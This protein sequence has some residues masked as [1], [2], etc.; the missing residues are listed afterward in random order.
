MSET[1]AVQ[2]TAVAT[3]ALAALALATAIL[4]LLAWRKQS[5]E[6]RDQ[7]EML[8]LQAEE[9]SQV[10]ADRE[11]E[12]LER[13]RA[14]AVQ[15]YVW[16][17]L[18]DDG[19]GLVA[20]VRN[21]SEQPVYDVTL[22]SEPDGIVRTWVEPL[23]PGTEVSRFYA[24]KEGVTAFDTWIALTFRDRADVLWRTWPNGR[25]E[26]LPKRPYPARTIIDKTPPRPAQ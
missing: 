14:Q 9:L 10:S 13:H 15:V 19:S 2:L 16:G 6:V 25:L 3:L 5:R 24:F 17:S 11:R 20:Y 7:A 12:A 18:E 22:H 23:M 4:A 8:R 21:T 26:E 1:F